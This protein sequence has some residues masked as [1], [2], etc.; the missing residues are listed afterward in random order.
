MH[1]EKYNLGKTVIQSNL[2][3]KEELINIRLLERAEKN[4]DFK[5]A[6]WNKSYFS[7]KWG[8]SI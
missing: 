7:N 8:W 6:K 2:I 5:K 1:R 3:N 4:E